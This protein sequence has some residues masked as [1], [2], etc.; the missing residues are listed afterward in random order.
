MSHA[1]E[2]PNWTIFL[3]VVPCVMLMVLSHYTD[4]PIGSLVLLMIITVAY[5]LP[6]GCAWSR[7]H[8]NTQAIVALNLFAG[9]T[10]VGWVIAMCWALTVPAP[11]LKGVQ[12]SP[13]EPV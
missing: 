2:L 3:I 10:F 7:R 4:A 13:G 11:T 6:S 9:W 8:R 5:W 12:S 1:R